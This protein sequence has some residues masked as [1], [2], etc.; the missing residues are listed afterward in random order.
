[1]QFSF[2]F[3]RQ[4]IYGTGYITLRIVEIVGE[5][6]SDVWNSYLNNLVHRPFEDLLNNFLFLFFIFFWKENNF[7]VQRPFEILL[8]NF[9]FFNFFERKITSYL[10]DTNLGNRYFCCFLFFFLIFFSFC[11]FDNWG[12]GIRPNDLNIKSLCDY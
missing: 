8:N 5:L 7:L 4:S 1:M 11:L 6:A 12:I 10:R 2:Y 3:A 9:F